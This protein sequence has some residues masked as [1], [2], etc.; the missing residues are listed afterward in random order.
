ML[1]TGISGSGKTTVA[2]RLA[3][4]GY[5]AVCTDAVPGLC[6]W[7]DPDGRSVERPPSPDLD[8]LG[9]HR[10]QW[11]PAVLD[12]LISTALIEEFPVFFVCGIADNS[13]WLRDRFDRMILLRLDEATLLE[14]IDQASRSN[15]FG[16]VGC[17]REFLRSRFGGWQEG[18]LTWADAVIDAR[19]EL[20]VVVD[21]VVSHALIHGRAADRPPG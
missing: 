21:Q 16:Q 14:R 8:W 11:R 17:T 3:A 1:V 2:H 12:A 19:A 18:L 20:T 10:W 15:D 7:V 6:H 5:R 9:A 4:M 13:Y